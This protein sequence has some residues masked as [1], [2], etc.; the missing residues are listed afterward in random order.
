MAERGEGSRWPLQDGETAQSYSTDIPTQS[1]NAT[2]IEYLH[3][4][5]GRVAEKIEGR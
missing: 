1:A 3:P 4:E 5:L 2:P